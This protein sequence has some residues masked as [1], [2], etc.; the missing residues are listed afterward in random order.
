MWV[1]NI[2]N[3]ADVLSIMR[4][5]KIVILIIKISVPI[6]L[7]LSLMIGYLRAVKD[8]DDDALNK[9]NKSAVAKIIAALLVFFI[10][11]LV[12]TIADAVDVNKN[13]YISCIKLA[14]TESINQALYDT[15]LERVHTA[16]N[17]L[18]KG[19][20]NSAVTA[21]NNI[22]EH[23]FK[24]GL[25]QQLAEIKEYLDLI[26]QI[27]T[28]KNNYDRGKFL[29]IEATIEKINDPNVKV[30]L[31]NMLNEVSTQE[32][33]NIKSGLFYNNYNDLDYYEV[34]PNNPT[35]NL[36]LVVYLHGEDRFDNGGLTGWIEKG[37]NEG[38]FFYLAPNSTNKTSKDE[39]KNLITTIVNKYKINQDKIII[40]GYS[41]GA[42]TALEM[43]NDYPKFFSSAIIVSGNTTN[44]NANNFKYTSIYA[45]TGDASE[46]LNY[47]KS[48][49]DKV[50]AIND[51][52]GNAKYS[53]IENRT[54][55]QMANAVQSNELLNW[56]LSQKRG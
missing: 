20:Y 14:T 42:S 23:Q 31:T 16:R 43:V 40:C 4:I 10:P 32:S 2:C 12:N 8:H 28:L 6:I 21:V 17:T 47:S 50:N 34:I 5:V 36:P 56:A 19:D 13:S 33:L 22:K 38:K 55:G 51:A 24:Y 37:N 7:L 30:K 26:D 45:I 25:E 35:T 48:L 18:S 11:D 54:H 15:A 29:Q 9:V 46:E 41:T 1:L 44:F 53:I 3:N 49:N 52:G 39:L 27:N